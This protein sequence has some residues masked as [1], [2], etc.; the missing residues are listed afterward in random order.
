MEIK[1]SEKA[2]KQIRKIKQKDKKSVLMIL[3]R[4]RQFAENPQ[5]NYNIKLLKGDLGE[6]KR[7]R[8]G[9]YR[10]IFDSNGV[11]VYEIKHQQGAYHD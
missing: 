5:S 9:N 7:L 8:V 11:Y 10:V 2:V 3:D 6:F 1:F 4:I